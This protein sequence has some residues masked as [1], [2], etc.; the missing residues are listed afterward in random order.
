MSNVIGIAHFIITVDIRTIVEH[1]VSKLLT[2]GHILSKIKG[3]KNGAFFNAFWYVLWK[4]ISISCFI[5]FPV[6]RKAKLCD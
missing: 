3:L 4:R 5:W 1:T 2:Y 6:S